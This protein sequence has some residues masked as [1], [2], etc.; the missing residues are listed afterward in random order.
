MAD[1]QKSSFS[2]RQLKLQATCALRLM[3]KHIVD[4]TRCIS[5]GV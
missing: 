1:L 4:N 5:R 2:K 3:C